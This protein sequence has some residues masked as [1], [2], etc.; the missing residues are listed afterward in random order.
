MGDVD[1]FFPVSFQGIVAED[2]VSDLADELHVSAE[3]FRRDC[4]IGAF[5]ARAHVKYA[6]GN[7]FSW[8]GKFLPL[9]S[10]VGIAAADDEYFV[11][12]SNQ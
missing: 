2:V 12:H 5:S 1:T 10:H 8:C 4:L 11:I 7:G 3:A 9:D 6:A